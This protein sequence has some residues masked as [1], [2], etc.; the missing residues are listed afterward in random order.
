M[1]L[2]QLCLHLAHS[3][4][5]PFPTPA[6][7]DP[8]T[9]REVSTGSRERE[10]NSLEMADPIPLEVESVNLFEGHSQCNN[11]NLSGIKDVE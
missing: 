3:P 1:H 9:S 7:M 6:N 10:D 4:A 8:W 2:F 5:I 11:N